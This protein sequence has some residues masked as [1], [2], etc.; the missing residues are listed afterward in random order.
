LI[1]YVGFT[2]ILKA[3]Y[4]TI[5]IKIKTVVVELFSLHIKLSSFRIAQKVRLTQRLFGKKDLYIGHFLQ[6]PFQISH[7]YWYLSKQMV[8]R[9]Q[10]NILDNNVVCLHF[11]YC[12]DL[13]MY[14]NYM[15]I[16][17]SN[18]SYN[19]TVPFLKP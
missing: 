15:H 19:K 7:L 12:F 17:G 6:Q 4:Q 8:S 3:K 13:K 2:V 10:N 5:M 18:Y 11:Y 14:H 1:K 16:I 9:I